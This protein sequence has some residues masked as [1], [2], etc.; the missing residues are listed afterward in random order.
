MRR[1]PRSSCEALAL[2]RRE[3]LLGS[4]SASLV[5]LT[6]TSLLAP[7]ARASA[8]A[9]TDETV[10]SLARR[11]AEAPY[12]I[13]AT[14]LP[15]WLA[16][17]N[18][19]EYRD[20][21]FNPSQALWRREGLPFQAQYFH[22]GF[23]FKDRV[24]LF[25]VAGGQARQVDYSPDLF[26]FRAAALRG[27]NAR[28]LGF[29]GMRLH[30]AI[31]GPDYFDEITAFLGASYFRAVAKGQSYGVSARGLAI[32][33]VQPAGEE[34]PVFRSF[35]MEQPAPG[36]T[37][38]VVHA[39]MDSASVAGA[40]RFSIEPG[41]ETV[42]DVQSRLYPRV[43]LRHAGIAPLTSMY[44]FGASDR[45]GV[46][47]YRPAVHDSDGLAL[48]TGAGEQIWRP[49][50][51]PALVQDS[52]FED[53]APRAFG[54]MQRQ[55]E[56]SDYADSE[57]HYEKR[58]SVWVEPVGD[59]GKG[60]VHLIELPTPDEYHDNIVAFWRP[61][62][63]LSAGTEHRFDYRLHWC[64]EH[65]WAP[66]LA[67]VVD[68]MIGAAADNRRRVI[69]DFKGG[70]LEGL[71]SEAG[72]T[73]DTWSNIGVISNVVAHPVDATGGWRI[74]FELDPAGAQ[75]VELHVRLVQGK[76]AVS[77]T[78]LYRWTA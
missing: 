14:D 65:S 72:V 38:I 53:N 24:Q 76:Q 43:E 45:V 4:L 28:D 71:G 44:Q 39:L 68:T 31:N 12:A 32:N 34:F 6:G 16:S 8:A 50:H 33:T 46:D 18:Y 35:W 5:A 60:A 11:L 21:R 30:A 69:I 59:W 47:D 7:R 9:F 77:E 26:N 1:L 20:I 2:H 13:P 57:A 40:F 36:A 3:L 56:F 67:T 51:N 52:G 23:L 55:R 27:R 19:D 54:L 73:A 74:G 37:R 49:L 66:G 17:I 25:T 75:A 29:A 42:F 10:P 41:I 78:W 22:R 48:M 64:N 15:A 58:P 61:A 70:V 63:P 62:A